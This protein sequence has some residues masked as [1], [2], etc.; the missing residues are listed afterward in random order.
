MSR[1][2][3]LGAVVAVLVV[4]GSL[5]GWVSALGD[6]ARAERAAEELRDTVDARTARA[7]AAEARLSLVRD[8]L[9]A[10]REVVDS[11]R[12]VASAQA[13]ELAREAEAISLE[14]VALTESF[15][16]AVEA[17]RATIPPEY[18]PAVDTIVE[19]AER[20]DEARSREIRA[21]EQ[22]AAE[23]RVALGLAESSISNLEE[24][25]AE[26]DSTHARIVSELR[27]ALEAQRA[28]TELWRE[29]ARPSFFGD[30]GTF[31]KGAA[32]GAAAACALTCR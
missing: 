1:R 30:L 20:R 21:R 29:E 14:A 24:Q 7:D 2:E 9:E 19:R 25:L 26:T 8:S 31:A 23:L 15:E 3:I 10:E 11:L 32:A 28:E 17:A 6:F 5:S 4:V 12:A 22:E 18:L 13:D 16:E 27:S